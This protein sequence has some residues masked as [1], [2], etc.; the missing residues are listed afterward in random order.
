[1]L[2]RRSYNAGVF[3]PPKSR[4]GR[5]EIPIAPGVARALWQLRKAAERAGDDEL[6]FATRTG[7][8]LDRRNLYSRIL[9]PAARAAGV[10]WAGFHTLRHTRATA[11]FR[12]GWNAKQVQRFLGHHSAAFTLDTY[13]HLLP[14]DLPEPGEPA[15][16]QVVHK[17][18]TRPAETGRNADTGE[19]AGIP[20]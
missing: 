15:A 12:A 13:A 2:V 9:K 19:A 1:V 18:S 3:S 10:P 16:L 6:V 8:P 20:L 5:R 11:L 7:G 17:V 14:D 4:Y